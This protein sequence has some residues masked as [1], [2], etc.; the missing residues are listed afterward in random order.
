MVSPAIKD[1][2]D[3]AVAAELERGA[4]AHGD[5]V[6]GAARLVFE[7]REEEIEQSGIAGAG[8]GREAEAFRLLARGGPA[9]RGFALRAGQ[10]DCEKRE[11][12]Q[13][14]PVFHRESSTI[15][16]REQVAWWRS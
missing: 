16:G 6:D 9:G 13:E 12:E 3:V 2:V 14:K 10:G 4:G 8:R 1:D 15:G 7:Y 5:H 11:K